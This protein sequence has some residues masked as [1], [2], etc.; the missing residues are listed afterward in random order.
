MAVM[1]PPLIKNRFAFF[2]V[3]LV[4]E[5]SHKRQEIDRSREPLSDRRGLRDTQG[6]Q[7]STFSIESRQSQYLAFRASY[8]ALESV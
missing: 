2:S 7:Y 6:A 8:P 1:M 5:N 3:G 4:E